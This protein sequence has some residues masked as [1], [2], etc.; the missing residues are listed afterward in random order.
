MEYFGYAGRML[1]VDLSRKTVRKEALDTKTVRRFIGGHG[2]NLRLIQD[3]LSPGIDPL[4]P[5]NPIVIGSGALVGTLAPG[6]TKVFATTKFAL[7]ATTDGKCYV[8]TGVSGGQG[9]GFRLKQAGYDHLV[10]TGRSEQP[11]YLQ[12]SDESV[13][14]R[15]ADSYWGKKDIYDTTDDLKKA[16]GKCGV[17]AIGRAG[18]NLC[19][20]SMALTDKKSTLGRSG[21]GAV[22]G[23]KNL[24]AIVV[25]GQGRIGV[26]DRLRFHRTLDTVRREYRDRVR[27]MGKFSEF[28]WELVFLHTMNPGIWSQERWNDLYGIHRLAEIKKR[29][30]NCTHC[31]MACGDDLAVDTGKYAGTRSMTGHYLWVPIIGQKME[32]EEIGASLSLIQRMNRDGICLCTASSII[33]WVTRRFTEGVIST[34]DTGGVVLDRSFHCYMDL[35]DRIIRREGIGDKLADGW[36][37]ASEWMGRDAR[38]DYVEGSGIAKGTDSIYPARAA[39]LDPMRFTMGLTSPRGGHAPTGVSGTGI[40]GLPVEQIRMEAAAF[41]VPEEAMN[42]IFQPTAYYGSFNVGRYTRYTED[43][44]SVINSTGTCTIYSALY[45]NRLQNL[46][47][48]Y[49]AATGIETT[50]MELIKRGERIFNLYKILNVREGFERKDDAFPPIWLKPL[51]TPDGTQA[52][53]D[54][55]REKKISAEDIERLLDDYYDERGWNVERGIPSTEKLEELGL[56]VTAIDE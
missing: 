54:Y 46:A 32:L 36:F 2:V 44:T 26:A 13:S 16:H 51:E 5:E 27:P 34:S 45:L 53:T 48:I 11:V 43:F 42:R 35:L 52:L 39:T 9:F 50:P 15:S 49:S 31:W 56:K 21:F 38:F 10:I 33:D 29:N 19:R 14:I 30:V 20:Y 40:P 47:E 4:S 12:I 8:A 22:M 18:E 17:V 41:G 25:A 37:A 6:A 55:H 1:H 7:P 23:S 3:L 28:S 24:K